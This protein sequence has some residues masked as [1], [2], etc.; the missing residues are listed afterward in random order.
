MGDV[1]L[2]AGVGGDGVEA[3]VEEVVQDGYRTVDIQE[4]GTKVVGT[5]EMGKR[6]A[7]AV[8]RA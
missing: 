3:A 5:S 4:E 2:E 7:A 8:R 1:G 6:I